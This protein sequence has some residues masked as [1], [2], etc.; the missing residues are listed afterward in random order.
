VPA[1]VKGL[2]RGGLVSATVY[3]APTQ[4]GPDGAQTFGPALPGAFAIKAS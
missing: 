3:T 1:G 2:P 4:A